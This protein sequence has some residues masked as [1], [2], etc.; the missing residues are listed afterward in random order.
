MHY[1]EQMSMTLKLLPG[2]HISTLRETFVNRYNLSS[3][4]SANPRLPVRQAFSCAILC[5]V[6]LYNIYKSHDGGYTITAF[7]GWTFPTE[8]RCLQTHRKFSTLERFLGWW[9][10]FPLVAVLQSP[11]KPQTA[12]YAVCKL[13]FSIGAGAHC[14]L[15][16][17]RQLPFL[18]TSA[19]CSQEKAHI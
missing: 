6:R 9:E 1:H 4:N 11:S 17:L 10:C 12:G 13:P 5:F 18:G 8:S 2:H 3:S 14:Y 15:S 7:P 19:Q 16:F